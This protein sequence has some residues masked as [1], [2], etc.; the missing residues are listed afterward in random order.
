M[1]FNI[2]NTSKRSTHSRSLKGFTLIEL[3][4][5]M[6]ITL[7]IVGLLLGMTKMAVTAWRSASAKTRSSNI[8]Q[9]VFDTVGRDLEGLV[10]RSGNDFEWFSIEEGEGELGPS[11]KSADIP[12]PLQITF[13]SAV[14]DRYNGQINTDD[15]EGGDVSTIRY[16]LVYQDQIE[17]G[18]DEKVYALYRERIDPDET[19]ETYLAGD[20]IGAIGSFN[21]T[22]ERANFLA[23]NIVDFTLSFNFE[24]TK[25]DSSKGYLRQVIS[26]G[27]VGNDLSIKGDSV[28]VGGNELDI[29]DGGSSP[30]LVGIDISAL[31]ISDGGM[32]ALETTSID[33]DT[34]FSE[35][36]NE[37]GTHYSKSVI[38]PQP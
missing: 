1:K 13:F 25:D 20:D 26:P 19:F 11:G 17:E 38:I 4:I 16:R 34:A 28:L 5:S 31:V 8:A 30:R 36:L 22:I 32:N 10:I 35:F 15:D 37:H 14:T 18:G 27:G 21:D 33:S 23:E 7:V 12:N 24:Y 29:P 2:T 9:E 3:L 6:T